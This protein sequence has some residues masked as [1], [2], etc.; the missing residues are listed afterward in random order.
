MNGRTAQTKM[1]KIRTLKV[2]SEMTILKICSI[3]VIIDFQY[4]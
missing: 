2:H 3:Y 1:L 4:C